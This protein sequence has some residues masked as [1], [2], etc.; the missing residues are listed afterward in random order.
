[1]ILLSTLCSLIPYLFVAAGYIMMEIQADQ[2]TP[3]QWT[4]T[5]ITSSLAF[6]FSLLAVIGVGAD[7]V[8]WGF[9][10]LLAGTPFYVW[11]TWKRKRPHEGED[12]QAEK[13]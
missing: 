1:M 2:L 6:V 12:S 4:K 8:Y 9:V 13:L 3:K 10:L 5:L 11:N 7:T